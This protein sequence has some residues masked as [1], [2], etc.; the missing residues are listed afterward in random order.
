MTLH[1]GRPVDSMRQNKYALRYYPNA[2]L[3]LMSRDW[4]VARLLSLNES[5]QRPFVFS[6]AIARQNV[7]S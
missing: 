1:K 2:E 6:V 5:L 7:S 3:Y 4:K